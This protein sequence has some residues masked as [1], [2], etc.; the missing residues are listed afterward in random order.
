MQRFLLLLFLGAT[1]VCASSLR[2]LQA[3]QPPDS[4]RASAAAPAPRRFPAGPAT[5]EG[6]TP[7][8]PCD[9]DSCWRPQHGTPVPPASTTINPEWPVEDVG[10]TPETRASMYKEGFRT[11]TRMEVASYYNASSGSVTFAENSCHF[12]HDG[13][14]DEPMEC[15]PGTDCEDCGNCPA[16]EELELPEALAGPAPAPW[17][18]PAP[19]LAAS[20]MPAMPAMPKAG[21]PAPVPAPMSEAVDWQ[22]GFMDH[23]QE[24]CIWACKLEGRQPPPRYRPLLAGPA[25]KGPPP[26]PCNEDNHAKQAV[27]ARH[28]ISGHT[29]QEARTRAEVLGTA[30]RNGYPPLP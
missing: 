19:G 5:W 2:K 8:P 3:T 1:L 18:P 11:I 13:E 29:P 9:C 26:M 24:C 6:T 4:A 22:T 16:Q 10:V 28:A 27:E 15:D 21:P 7:L 14:C 23:G 12:A 30:M 17:I 20:L 25:P